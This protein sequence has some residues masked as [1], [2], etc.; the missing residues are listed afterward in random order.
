MIAPL[1]PYHGLAIG[2]LIG[3]PGA[4]PAPRPPLMKRM[5]V[6]RP[7]RE[8]DLVLG[9]VV[10]VRAMAGQISH[11]MCGGC[12]ALY[13][14]EL[15]ELLALS[16]RICVIYEGRIVGEVADHDVDRLGLMMAG[17]A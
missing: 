12:A 15:D 13:A 2:T 6:G 10:C 4:L 9:W 17:S 11:G 1:A 5:C 16:D 3:N 7:G 8:C 14:E